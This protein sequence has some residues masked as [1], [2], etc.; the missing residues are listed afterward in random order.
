MASGVLVN[1]QCKLKFD[2]IKKGKKHR[3]LVFVIENE[4]EINIEK[5]Y[6]KSQLAKN[7]TTSCL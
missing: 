3:Y 2:E 4:K 7:G 6:D 5:K 1:Q